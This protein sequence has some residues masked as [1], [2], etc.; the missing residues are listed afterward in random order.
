[1]EKDYEKIIN[2]YSKL[3]KDLGST[4]RAH[5]NKLK[6]SQETLSELSKINQF[7]ISRIES[8]IVKVPKF[9]TL[10][11]I[12]VGMNLHY[13]FIEDILGK[14]GYMGVLYPTNIGNNKEYIVYLDILIKAQDLT[15]DECNNILKK[16]GI[17]PV[18]DIK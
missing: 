15:I 18:I 6:I 13:V 7:T 16:N 5:R 11:A 8:G 1:M 14:S 2:L 3:P 10:V 17:D 4:I 9:E 12:M